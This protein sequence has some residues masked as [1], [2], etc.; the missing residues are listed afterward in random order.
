MTS[1][2]RATAADV[3]AVIDL[4]VRAFDDDPVMNWLIRQ[5]E[6][7][8]AAFHRFFEISVRD[9][10]MPHGYVFTTDDHAGAA[11]WAPPEG[12]QIGLWQQLRLMPDYVRVV[13]ARRFL[14]AMASVSRLEARHPTT[15]HYYLFEIGVEAAFQ[16]RGVGSAL[17]REVL[18]ECD[19]ERMPAYLENSKER[20]LPLYERH[21]FRVTEKWLMAPDGPPVWLM[22]RDPR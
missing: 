4:L 1:I 17:L 20:N 10:T 13:G 3:P 19:R 18:E 8:A 9:L 16:G 12:W 6:R 11:A 7:R 22:W 15:P 21:G 14:S 5:D 2:R